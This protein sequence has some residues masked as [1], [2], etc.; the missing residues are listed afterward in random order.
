MPEPDKTDWNEVEIAIYE[1]AKLYPMSV[2]A[3]TLYV[4]DGVVKATVRDR[5]IDKFRCDAELRP[6][7]DST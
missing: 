4:E 6:T 1:M 3:I 7:L 2:R 5:K